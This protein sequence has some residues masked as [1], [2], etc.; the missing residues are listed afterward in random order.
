MVGHGQGFES[1]LQ[2][3]EIFEVI[4]KF[5]TEVLLVRLGVIFSNNVLRFKI[6]LC[7]QTVIKYTYKINTIFNRI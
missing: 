1:E 6:P 2:T 4:R 7:Q 5:E 3:D